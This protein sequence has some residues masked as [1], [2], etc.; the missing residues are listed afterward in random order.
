MDPSSSTFTTNHLLFLQL[1]LDAGSPRQALPIL[2]KDIYC[3]PG[4]VPKE[5]DQRLWCSD[6]DLS[7]TYITKG[8]GIS[9]ALAAVDVQEYY[10]LGAYVYI[11]LRM[12]DR[13]RLF[14]EL[15]LATPSQ[16]HAVDFFMV[17]AYKK[18]LLLGLL[19]QGRSFKS[20]Q[21][22]DQSSLRTIQNLSKHY[23]VLVE[24]FQNRDLQKFYAEMDVAMDLYHE[25]CTCIVSVM[26]CC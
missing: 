18:L 9:G 5:I 11:G 13:A 23:S 6:N 16:G 7:S 21:T 12:H 14:L 4:H 22:V 2:D 20:S 17:E 24:A 25:V 19:A 26:H 10:L 3:F 8:S 15:V 1:C